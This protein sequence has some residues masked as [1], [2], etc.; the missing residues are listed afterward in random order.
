MVET[1]TQTMKWTTFGRHRILHADY[2]KLE[3][4]KIAVAVK[5]N[6][7]A[8]EELGRQGHKDLLVLTDVT[9]TEVD[10]VVVTAFM[11]VASAMRP[12]TRASAVVGMGMARTVMLKVVN[13]FSAVETHPADSIDEAK[14]WL[15]SQASS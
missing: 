13:S 1:L 3:A 5:E 10:H 15:V 11:K 7:T 8:I 14:K 4:D 12:F 9:D 2:R 6:Q